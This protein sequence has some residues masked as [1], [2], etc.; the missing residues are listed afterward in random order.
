MLK[1]FN[2]L[3]WLR[4]IGEFIYHWGLSAPWSEAPKAI[5]IVALV[6][7]LIVLG[8]ISIKDDEGSGWRTRLLNAQLM[9]AWESEKYETAELVLRRQLDA[10]PDDADIVYRLALA[11]DRQD[12]TEEALDLM[13]DIVRLKGHEPSARW[14]LQNSYVGKQWTS[15]SEDERVEFGDLLKLIHEERPDD[16]GIK[17]LYADYLIASERLSLAIPLLEDLAKVQPMRGLQ[18]AAISRRLGNESNALRLAELALKSV[19][20]MLLEDPTNAV[21]ALAVCQNQLFM[22]Q[23]PD[24]IRTLDQAVQVVKTNE[25]RIRLNQAMGDAIVAWI[26]YIQDTPD[27]SLQVRIKVLKMLQTALNYAPNN[28]RVLTLVADQVLS[29]VDEDD[30]QINTLRQ[31]LITGSSPGISHFVQGTAALMKDD[32]DNAMMHLKIASELM[33]R[34]GAILNNLAVAMTTRPGGD[35]NQA[36]KIANTAIQQT[37]EPT[38]HFYETRGQILF[39]LRRYLDAVPDLER[40]LEIPSLAIN[41]HET[42]ADCYKEIGESELSRQHLLA[43]KDLARASGSPASATP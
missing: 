18:A 38:A 26:Q 7:A 20:K 12:E 22:R 14:I 35:L 17:Q 23:Y 6:A 19:S 43:A 11:R 33:P 30:D 1:Y 28:P 15:L 39:R 25:D 37:P 10:Q 4:W 2:P 8:V 42:L 36:L 21:L 13:R 3:S 34:S 24:A 40:A 27:D 16:L 9:D 41:A 29:T 32:V 5:P 31:A